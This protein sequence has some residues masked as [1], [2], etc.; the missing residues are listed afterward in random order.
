MKKVLCF[1]VCLFIFTNVYA[2]DLSSK[3]VILYNLN[4][5]KVIYEVNSKEKTSIASLTKIMTTLVAIEKINNLDD[6]VTITYNMT[7]DLIKLNAAVI[8]LKVGKSYTYRDLL[9]A[10]MLP[11][12]ADAARALAYSLAGTESLYVEWMNN[13]ANELGLNLHFANVIGLDDALNYGTV[14]DVAS[15][16]KIA[17][18][19]NTF[20][21]IFETA[22]Y[23]LTNGMKV[24][25]SMRDSALTYHLNIDYILG[26]KTGY[27]LDAGKCLASIAYDKI[28]DISYMLV[29]TGASINKDN[30][31]HILDATKIYEYYFNNYKYHTLVSKDTNVLSI[32][33]PYSKS[34]AYIT[35]NEDIKYYTN[36]INNDLIKIEYNGLNRINKTMNKGKFLGTIK[37]FYD[38]NL[39]K[40]ENAYLKETVKFSIL[41]FIKVYILWFILAFIIWIITCILIIKKRKEKICI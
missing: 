35:I 36:E 7:H 5:D 17:L 31:Y 8:G 38:G 15:L 29:T 6:E 4:E 18:K 19:N 24:K 10:T 26:G 12:A 25:S 3:N 37:V 34:S 2:L 28:N 39:V 40:E 30:A 11:S 32:D 23:T 21:E 20:K 41:M 33:A 16:L 27:T 14:Y 1:L 13:K 22:E 9:Y